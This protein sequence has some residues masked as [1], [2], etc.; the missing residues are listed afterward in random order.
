M[1]RQQTK[2]TQMLDK[3]YANGIFKEVY[4]TDKT[5]V[6]NVFNQM[7]VAFNLDIMAEYE[8]QYPGITMN[9]DGLRR[10]VE[11]E[12]FVIRYIQDLSPKDREEALMVVDEKFLKHMITNKDKFSRKPVSRDVDLAYEQELIAS[13]R[14]QGELASMLGEV[15]AQSLAAAQQKGVPSQK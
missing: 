5:V 11:D 6:C 12:N 13:Q 8:G 3:F 15:Q 10:V 7:Y 14:K 9:A 1:A 2:F 4:G